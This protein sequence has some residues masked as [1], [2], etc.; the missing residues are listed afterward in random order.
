M[1][2]FAYDYGLY[3][4]VIVTD[5]TEDNSYVYDWGTDQDVD[6]SVL[7]STRLAEL[8]VARKQPIIPVPI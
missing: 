8:E 5:G 6:V 3:Y 2:A 1:F 7:E 4:Q